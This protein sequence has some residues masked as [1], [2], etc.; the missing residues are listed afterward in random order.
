M[1]RIRCNDNADTKPWTLKTASI[2]ING[3]NTNIWR[4]LREIHNHRIDITFVQEPKIYSCDTLDKIKYTW[5]QISL[6]EAY[7][8]PA[9]ASRS[10]GVAILLSYNATNTL[11]HRRILETTSPQ[12]RYLAIVTQLH[13]TPLTLHCIYA[14]VE[15][16]HRATF[17]DTLPTTSSSTE[18]IVGG[19]YNCYTDPA[20]D[21]KDG[22]AAASAGA[23]NLTIWMAHLHLADLWRTQHPSSRDYTSPRNTSRI[24]RIL[25]SPTIAKIFQSSISNPI[26]GSDHRCP[27]V[28]FSSSPINKTKPRWQSPTWLAKKSAP[29]INAILE[30]YANRQPQPAHNALAKLMTRVKKTC[31]RIQTEA[32]LHRA[33]RT[34]RARQRWLQ[35][36][37]TAIHHPTQ[38]N[39][40]N[41]WSA[42]NQ[43]TTIAAETKELKK[44]SAFDK[45]LTREETTSKTFF[46]RNRPHNVTPPIP[47]VL[48]D[49]G[50][51]STE[52]TDIKRIHQAYWSRLFSATGGDTE[53][54]PSHDEML[55]T[56][57]DLP[58]LKR[59]ARDELEKDITEE[60][61]NETI[62][63]LAMNK[64][65]GPDGL[66]A[67][68]FKENRSSWAKTLTPLFQEILRSNQPLPTMFTESVIALAYKK[69]DPLAPRNY[70]PISLINVIAKIMTGT[71]N[72]R[73]RRHLD[74]IIPQ[75]QTGFVPGRS[76]SEN[77]IF[78]QDAL[79]YAQTR[80]PNAIVVSL[81]FEKAYD[82][83][84]W[85]YLTQVLSKSGFGPRFVRFVEKIYHNRSARFIIN[86]DVTTPFA[87]ERGV[88]QGDPISPSLFVISTTPLCLALQRKSTSHGIPITEDSAAPAAVCYADDTNLVARSPQ[89]AAELCS[90]A[91]DFCKATGAKL[92]FEKCIAISATP[93]RGYLPNG[94]RILDANETTTILGI[95]MGT[96]ITRHQQIEHVINKMIMRTAK[97]QRIGRT[98][99]GKITIARSIISSTL[100]YTLSV[101]STIPQEAQL[102]QNVITNYINKQDRIDWRGNR[103][104]GNLPAQT[105]YTP[106]LE[107]GWGMTPIRRT[108]ETR[109]LAMLRNLINEKRRGI[110]KPW[111][112]FMTKATLEGLSGWATRWT[113]ILLWPPTRPNSSLTIGNWNT[114]HPWWQSVWATW[115]KQ[116]WRPHPN[117]LPREEL[118]RW[119]IWNNAILAFDHG[120]SR[121]LWKMSPH[122]ATQQ[123]YATLRSLSFLTF[124]DFM[125]GDNIM[126]GSQLH[127]LTKQRSTHLLATNT[128]PS[129]PLRT[130]T[131]ITNNVR[132]L[133]LHTLTKWESTQSN[134]TESTTTDGGLIQANWTHK[135]GST[136]HTATNKQ[137]ALAVAADE[138]KRP[139]VPTL[140]VN[141]TRINVDWKW[142]QRAMRHLAPTRQ[143]LLM[144]L[145]RNGLPLGIKRIAWAAQSQ[146]RCLNCSENVVETA[147]HLFYNCCFAKD[148]WTKW[149][150]GWRTFE[151]ASMTWTDIIAAKRVRLTTWTNEL[152]KEGEI[153]DQVWTIIKACVIKVIWLERNRRVFHTETDTLTSNQRS[154][155]AK[156][157]I[158]AHLASILRRTEP[159]KKRVITEVYKALQTSSPLY[160]STIARAT[161]IYRLSNRNINRNHNHNHNHNNNQ[162]STPRGRNNRRN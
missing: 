5:N 1:T 112:T 55:S 22:G 146:T 154:H 31:Q 151:G 107:G 18:H 137:I 157:D 90:I 53:R 117:S 162:Q 8:H 34:S 9:T 71:M 155:Q 91:S 43:L 124:A 156:D 121:P 123:H 108:I 23:R 6:G 65:A 134:R 116:K 96:T 125:R 147:S 72:A 86:G 52:T 54:L 144:R 128:N 141:G 41:A 45:H 3:L 87:I 140:R 143:D 64:A 119:P 62:R 27:I 32:T 81:D 129:I 42:H 2:N 10:G 136:F 95:R 59:T 99:R 110:T 89:H 131:N 63:K 78:I 83:V 25:A 105:Y 61:I 85:T 158:C 36:Y 82:R 149:G 161:E 160:Y 58:Q 122:P 17:F 126:T 153:L 24:D 29:Q 70:R 152:P 38:N 118:I 142:E 94:I 135:T 127:H 114:L 48:T 98:I 133:W 75:L 97:W 113:D 28:T 33:D 49:N 47:G 84:Q 80:C 138:R 35:A 50:L 21:H 14:P 60:E 88:Q 13:N 130:C 104:R 145:T 139:L 56:I 100:W 40:T 150:S 4:K 115:M 66:R 93:S 120:L 101:L 106:T 92:N 7:L 20:R 69:G 132:K 44:A 76:I 11:Q 12:H 30:G 51:R 102:I 16:E 159:A 26:G 79:H 103:K 39:I 15:R 67:E 46:E 77:I 19:D 37:T 111:H 109:K 148:L 68:I 73:L 57:L 74:D